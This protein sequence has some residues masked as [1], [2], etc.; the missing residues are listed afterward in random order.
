MRAL[1][2][3]R[4]GWA[5]DRF[6]GTMTSNTLALPEGWAGSRH[7]AGVRGGASS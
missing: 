6:K 2:N 4:L 1:F 7:R 3:L 5:V